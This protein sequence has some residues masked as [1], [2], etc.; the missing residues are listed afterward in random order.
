MEC[1]QLEK[2]IYEKL[3]S[4]CSVTSVKPYGL[5]IM[6]FVKNNEPLLRDEQIVRELA[7]E[8]KKKILIR[9]EQS[10]V[11]PIEEAKKIIKELIPEDAGITHI[12]FLPQMSEVY[13][14]SLKP[15]LVIGKGGQTL[16]NI[17]LKTKWAPITQRT[18][19]MPSA[20][21][22]GIRN[23]MIANIDERKKFLFD[24]GKK[25]CREMPK[26]DWLRTVSLGGYREVGRSS[27]LVQTPNSRILV[28]CGVNTAVSGKNAYPYLDMLGFPLQKLDG[29]VVTHAHMDHV[30]FIPY[31]Y[32]YGYEGPVY[33]TPPT[34][35]LMVL[36]Q[37][38]YINLS[39]KFFNEEPPY[40]KKDI[41]TE[42]KHVVPVNY[43]EVVD[44]T[45]EIKLTFYNAGHIL[46][47]ASVHLHIGGGMHNVVFT[48]DFKFGF[49]RLFEPANTHFPR[50]ETL[51]MEST[52]G[53]RDDITPNRIESE[54]RLIKVIEDTIAKKGKVL[55]PVFAV[56]RSQEIMLVLEQYHRRNPNFNV[57]V[58]IDGMI[59]E[60]SAI[61]TAYPEYLKE[62]VRKRILSN[63]SP[64]E[65]EI[66]HIAK[67]EDRTDIV[68][69][70]PAVILAP[71]GMLTG[72]P[73][74][75]YLKLMA[76]DKNN[77][78]IFVGYQAA[79][80]LGH[81][82]Q[83]GEKE[84]SILGDDGR[85]KTLK[86]EMNVETVEGFS[87]H[88]DRSQLMAYVRNLSPRPDR[89]ITMHGDWGK[90]EDLAKSVSHFLRRSA[91][92]MMNLEA[93]R[94]R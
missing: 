1:K 62:Y 33:A 38:D 25:V 6:V 34:I 89:V 7:S 87:G 40:S 67:G 78:L 24:L 68:D 26:S 44:I 57:P 83:S 46:G 90:T 16:K 42:L 28:D 54:N 9:V 48:G 82:I 32:K 29:I 31:L 60:A 30:G 23:S 84:I 43:Y 4:E 3:P 76:G 8:L 10:N 53:G 64:F 58:Y 92:A 91:N 63:N 22:K 39:K 35:D 52:Y 77:T 73:S 71:S 93:I 81:R 13:I 18:P 20:T 21:I 74:Y 5:Y 79:N 12:R 59:L 36:L 61:H 41:Q 69:G 66:I 56:G 94:L 37:Q 51:Y 88:S 19:T 72:G 65:S 14:D 80:S 17:F 75:E 27:T 85:S 15:G 86:I 55:I 11:V 50:L 49:T 45:P 2:M 47:S 70:E